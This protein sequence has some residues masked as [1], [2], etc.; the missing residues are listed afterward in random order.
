MPLAREVTTLF[1]FYCFFCQSKE[2]SLALIN[3]KSLELFVELVIFMRD[4]EKSFRWDTA[5]IET[6][7]SKS[8]PLLYADSIE[9]ELGCLNGSNITLLN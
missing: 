5:H 9:S 7:A 3:I 1:L 6:S 4:I 2:T 8:S